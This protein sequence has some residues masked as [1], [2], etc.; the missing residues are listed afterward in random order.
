MGGTG[1]TREGRIEGGRV[2][3]RY[4]QIFLAAPT[5]FKSSLGQVADRFQFTIL[6][7]VATSVLPN[8]VHPHANNGTNVHTAFRATVDS[9]GNPNLSTEISYLNLQ[10]DVLWGTPGSVRLDVVEGPLTQ[11]TAV[12]DL[13][14]GSAQLTAARIQQIQSHI[15]GG[16]SVPVIM[17]RP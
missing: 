17:V 10:A 9:F 5:R 6:T 8:Q 1:S 16:A 13:K 7:V 12:Y 15:P 11:P 4:L 2:Y 3:L 14:T